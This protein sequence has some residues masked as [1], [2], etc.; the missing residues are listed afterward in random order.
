VNVTAESA[1]N[2]NALAILDAAVDAILT[3]DSGGNI[4]WVNEATLGMFGYDE[5]E[6]IGAPMTVLM[7]SPHRERH[8]QYVDN[9]VKTGKAQIIGIGRELVARHKDGHEF[10]IYLGISEVALDEG[11]AFT[12]IIRDLTDQKAAQ[13]SVIEQQQRLAHVGRLSTMGEM[14]ASI[15]HEIN[16]PLTAISMYAQ[17]CIRMLDSENY[18]KDKLKDALVKLN[19]QSLRAG[20]VIER[21]Q[22]FVRNEGGQR[23]F[24]DINILI[25]ELQHLVVNDAKLHDIELQLNLDPTIEVIFCDPVQIQQVAINLVR[26]AID[27][28]AEI[29]CRWGRT[30][31]VCTR[32]TDSQIEVA[33]I[34]TGPGVAPE[35]ESKVFTAFETT[36]ATG[37]GMGLSICRTIIDSH[38]GVLNFRNND[39]HGATFYF[40]LPRRS[41]ND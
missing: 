36:K 34:D 4:G 37:M 21:I 25:R 12:G 26:N 20:E 24:V 31:E 6:L 9:Y 30:I 14:T 18:D 39:G 10:P 7:S 5:N 1:I 38:D 33:V 41:P 15:A 29:G 8:Q 28:M 17:S 11:T 40:R 3:M 22:R 19:R 35:V 13:Q 32:Q 16:Q 23:E 2:N 27:A